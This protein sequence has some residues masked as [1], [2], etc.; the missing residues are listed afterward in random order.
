MDPQAALHRAL[1]EAVPAQ[2]TTLSAGQKWHQ[3][4]RAASLLL[5]NLHLAERGCWDYFND[6]ERAQRDFEQWTRGMTTREGVRPGPRALAPVQYEARYLTFTMAFLIEQDSWSDLALRGYCNV[7]ESKL[8][9]RDTFGHILRNF[10]WVSFACVKADVAYLIPRD[11]EW[12][13][14]A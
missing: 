6:D 11:L 7:P 8:W 10:G 2:N 13:L 14:T 3:Y 4:Q 9:Q 5:N 12:A 1:L